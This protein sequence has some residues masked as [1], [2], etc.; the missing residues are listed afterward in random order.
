MSL[1]LE[2]DITFGAILRVVLFPC[3]YDKCT[4][5]EFQWKKV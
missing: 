3:Q 1:F 4:D 2:N 5:M